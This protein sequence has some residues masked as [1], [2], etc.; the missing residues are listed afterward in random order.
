M[1]DSGHSSTLT[2]STTDADELSEVFHWTSSDDPAP[3]PSGIP[4]EVVEVESDE[5]SPCKR[6]KTHAAHVRRGARTFLLPQ[7][8][9]SHTGDQERKVLWDSLQLTPS[10]ATRALCCCGCGRLRGDTPCCSSYMI[11][12]FRCHGCGSDRMFMNGEKYHKSPDCMIFMATP[13]CYSCHEIQT[14][15][16]CQPVHLERVEAC[17]RCKTT[18]YFSGDPHI[19]VHGL[20]CERRLLEERRLILGCVLPCS[21]ELSTDEE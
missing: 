13:R 9:H 1:A 15:C 12:A 21:E 10:G 19:P 4:V 7:F 6:V 14:N 18:L 3:P 17:T 8:D 20:F 16:K 11:S 5:E 2:C